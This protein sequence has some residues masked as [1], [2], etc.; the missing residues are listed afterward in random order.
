MFS[1]L[2]NAEAAGL[3][4]FPLTVLSHNS[5]LSMTMT[6][7]TNRKNGGAFAPWADQIFQAFSF[8]IFLVWHRNTN[9]ASRN[10]AGWQRRNIGKYV[11]HYSRLLRDY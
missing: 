11:K 1:L 9:K 2:P 6:L 4:T 10:N 8:N 3:V 5:T 7:I